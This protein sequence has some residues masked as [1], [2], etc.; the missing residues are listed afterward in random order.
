[1]WQEAYNNTWLK[2]SCER[3]GVKRMKKRTILLSLLL[4]LALLVASASMAF[5]NSKGKPTDFTATMTVL[6]ISPDPPTSIPPPAEPGENLRWLVRDRV[7]LGMV[8]GDIAGGFSVVYDA[9]VDLNQAGT[10]HGTL[11]FDCGPLGTIHGLLR[12]RTL[13]G[14]PVLLPGDF[15]ANP[16][17][18]LLPEEVKGTIMYLQSLGYNFALL[19]IGLDGSVTLQGGTGSYEGIQG[20]AKCEGVVVN[21]IIAIG[22]PPFGGHIVAIAPSNMTLTGKWH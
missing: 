22:P 13:P 20:T 10:L 8:S 11:D 5:A 15:L 6:G 4:C 17:Y 9:N 1:M 16:P 12:G 18:S 2:I 14:E 3:E 19:P 21:A 7:V